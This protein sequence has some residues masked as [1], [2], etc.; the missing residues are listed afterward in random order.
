MIARLL[1]VTVPLLVAATVT[2]SDARHWV[3][4]A[5]KGFATTAAEQAAVADLIRTYPSRAIERRALR[6]TDPGLFDGRDLPVASAYI[7]AVEAIGAREHVQSRWLNAIS[8][9]ATPGQL[10]RISQLPFVDRVEAVRRGRR[11]E[12]DATPVPAPVGGPTQS[13]NFYGL[14][15]D[16]LAQ[17]GVTDIHARGAT[18]AGVIIGIVDSGFQRTHVAFNEPG[19]PLVVVAEY[20]FVDDDEETGPEDGDASNQHIHGSYV[21]GSLGGYRPGEYVGG[22]YDASFV[23][24]KT[25]DRE[26]EYPGEEDNVVAGLEFCEFH[27][28][29]VVNSSLGYIAWYSQSDLNG[30]TAVSTVGVNVATSNGMFVCQAAGNLGHDGNPSTSHLV[31]PADS[32][33]GITVGA[34]SSSG[35]TAGFSSD[36]P[37]ADGRI[38]PELMARG[39]SVSVMRTLDDVT[40]NTT[41][42]T[43]HSTPLVTAAVACLIQ[44]RPA[45]TV[46]RLRSF[47]FGT[48]SQGS[49]D[50]LRIRGFG[51]PDALEAA[52]TDCNGDSAPDP[53]SCP[54]DVDADGMVTFDDLLDVLVAWGPCAVCAED[55]DANGVI[56]SFDLIEQ[57]ERWG[58]CP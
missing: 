27:G 33:M 25:E 22:A 12:F 42:G 38:K 16:Q 9:H 6:R 13:G 43:S 29:D 52:L 18:G 17:V 23:L 20:D 40:Y 49:A 34:V 50:P 55:V 8:V 31:A 1:F 41:S 36:G 35:A 46:P 39:V 45:W 3:F 14:T 30:V 24:C 4:F 10:E 7:A 15:F 37:T 58:A 19:H 26:A 32:F 47:L 57:I 53:C 48:G 28:A 5:D 11:N 21:L 44:A 54:G 56:D 51:I 2:A